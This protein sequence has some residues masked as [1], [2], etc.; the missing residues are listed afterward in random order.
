MAGQYEYKPLIIR[1][2]AGDWIEIK[3]H[4]LFDEDRPIPYFDYPTV[5]LEKKTQAFDEGVIEST[6]F[7]I[8]PGK[9]FRH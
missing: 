8:R 9:A 6:V 3:L 5:P 1:A 7:K 4:N 2:N